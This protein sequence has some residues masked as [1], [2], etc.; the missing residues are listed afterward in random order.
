MKIRPQLEGEVC[1]EQMRCLSSSLARIKKRF[2]L[3]REEKAT[4]IGM[5]KHDGHALIAARAAIH[6]SVSSQRSPGSKDL[7]LRTLLL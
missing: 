5:E 3:I 4:P 2:H 7:R 6:G 1:K